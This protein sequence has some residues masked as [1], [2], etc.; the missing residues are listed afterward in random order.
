MARHT[1]L[2]AEVKE[3]IEI[4]KILAT[5]RVPSKEELMYKDALV[6]VK[7]IQQFILDT[8]ENSTW[9]KKSGYKLPFYFNF[10]ELCNNTIIVFSSLKYL[11]EDIRATICGK[12]NID[13]TILGKF[14]DS[15][16]SGAYYS[17][18][19]GTVVDGIPCNVMDTREAYKALTE[20]MEI[21]SDYFDVDFARLPRLY[22]N[23]RAKA[24]ADEKA[25]VDGEALE[26][27]PNNNNKDSNEEKSTEDIPFLNV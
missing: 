7:D 4:D 17:P 9:S 24:M 14:N 10:D 13:S 21:T 26:V 3:E 12:Y 5:P 18:T 23:A 22:D 19:K 27:T 1:I 2:L 15:I 11:P 16:G 25:I 6:V 8:V 20:A